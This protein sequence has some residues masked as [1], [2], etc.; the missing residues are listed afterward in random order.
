MKER[1]RINPVTS[2]I[3]LQLLEPD[4]DGQLYEEREISVRKEAEIAS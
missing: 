3:E 4:T 1:I 2:K